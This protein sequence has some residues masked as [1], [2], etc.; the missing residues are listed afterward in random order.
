MGYKLILSNNEKAKIVEMLYEGKVTVKVAKT[1]IRDHRT[2]KKFIW[3]QAK[4]SVC[5]EK[6]KTWMFV[7][8]LMNRN[9]FE[10]RDA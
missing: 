9:S 10:E 4:C 1:F 5:A 2:L 6:G 8:Y 3:N 7:L